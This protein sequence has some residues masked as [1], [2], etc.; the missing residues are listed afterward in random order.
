VNS[1]WVKQFTHLLCTAMIWRIVFILLYL[2][3][4]GHRAQSQGYNWVT[5]GQKKTNIKNLSIEAGLGLRMYFGDIQQK[6]ALFN[7]VKFSYGI[8]ARYQLRTGLGAAIQLEG[9]KYKGKAEYG[10]YPDAL[11][12][13]E[14]K[15]WG[16]H[17]IIQYS[18]LQWEDFTRRQFTDRDPVTKTNLYVGAGFGGALFSSSF[19][20]RTYKL[21]RQ[22]D[23]VGRD[24]TIAFAIDNSGSS[25]GIALYVPAV[26]GFR[27]RIK[28]NW[29]IGFELQRHFYITKTVDAF[30]SKKYDG[31]GTFTMRLNYTFG[32][33]KRKGDA[34]KISPK[35]RFK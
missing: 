33:P 20:Q 31:M 25:A 7:P 24:S 26:F 32:Q 23:S 16:G 17:L 13:M 34:K 22:T 21:T 19:T 6:G 29:A 3:G 18:W 27:Y 14:G 30:T 15:L 4:T 2:I 1:G 5:P 11:A 35:G 8:G 10:G 28:P 12:E 9:R